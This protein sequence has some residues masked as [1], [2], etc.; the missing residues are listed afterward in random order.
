MKHSLF[1]AILILPFAAVG[2]N[3]YVSTSGTD[4]NEGV[5]PSSPLLTIQKAVDLCAAGDTVFVAEG[6]YRQSVTMRN[7]VSLIGKAGTILDGT[8]LGCRL[9][10]AAGKGKNINFTE[11]TLIENITLQNAR[12]DG[13]GGAAL[14]SGNVTMRYCTVRG[15]SAEQAGGVLIK[16]DLAEASALG[17][18]LEYCLIHNCSATGHNWPDAGGV[19]NFDGIVDHC[20]IV[21][22]YGDRYG[23]IHSESTV[24]NT[25]MW[26]NL[27]EDGF[28][29]PANYVSDES[30]SAYSTNYAN[31]GFEIDFFCEPWLS[32][33]N[34]DKDAPQFL[35]PTNFAGVPLSA[36]ENA[37]MLAA[38]YSLRS[39]SPL[40][41]KAGASGYE[42]RVAK[43]TNI[44]I[45]E[46]TLYIIE[47]GQGS[48]HA[49]VTPYETSDKTIQWSVS[50]DIVSID[51]EGRL[52]AHSVGKTVVTA[53]CGDIRDSA[54]VTVTPKPVVIVHRDV[55]L[56]DSL[57]HIEDYTT[58]SYIPLLIAK[59][60]AR[61][62]SSEH[63]LQA[64]RYAISDLQDNE[65]PYCMV[66]NINGDPATRM[67]FC[68]FTNEGIS[69]GEVQVIRK[70]N[71]TTQ[72]FERGK[73]VSTI[74]AD[75]TTTP[76]L[77]YAI[78][79]S[80]I[81]K[82]AR[83]DKNTSFRYVSHKAVATSLRP[84]SDYS[85]RVGYDGHWSEIMQF[86]TEDRRQKDF[87]FI[88]MTDSH[89][90]NRE[91]VDAA[92]L[93]A[94]AVAANE[95]DAR[96][97]VF[98]GDFV[99]TGTQNNS[100]W[101]WE[102]WFEEALKPVISI[103]PIVP[104]DGNH[105]DSPLLNYT[106]HF[107]TDSSFNTE[108]KVKPQFA[109]ITYSFQYG[110][111]LLMAYSM[112]DFWHGD[113]SYENLTSEYFSRDL[114][115]WFERQV[116]KHPK[117]QYRVALVHKNL[118][119][120]SDH[121]RDK[122]TPLMRQTLLPVFKECEIDL[123]L[124]GHDHTYEVI[125]PV[126]PDTRT[127]ILSAISEQETVPIDSVKN[128]TG[129]RGGTYDVSDGT[130]YFIGATCGAKRY[131]PLTRQEM[132][133]AYNT[134]KLSNY[135]DLFTGMFGQPGAPSYTRITVTKKA[136]LLDSFK[137][138]PDGSTTLFNSMRVVRS[139]KHK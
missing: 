114:A 118:F 76:P 8:G 61:S 78:S 22:N 129:K 29:D 107:N 93:C 12:H 133:D 46:D 112:Q 97:C 105:D 64:L 63:N 102:R 119:S 32:G 54:V 42:P 4:S 135:F 104:T 73:G 113:Y 109:G 75:A 10:T 116:K 56:A 2:A 37:M 108:T 126:D 52:T 11:P 127:P 3:R 59:E 43:C 122:E 50:S 9:I 137:V 33:N 44:D 87:S 111:M 130:M 70:R 79:T 16:G 47:D 103:M 74:H 17:A 7:G 18:K 80:G 72:D 34:R 55:L 139:R 95:R 82:A 94:T 5:K 96:F 91:Y 69:D 90:Q 84:G 99:D 60:T 48:L 35:F 30:L 121:Q 83:L 138:N 19:A 117:A 132:D 15:C 92:K 45:L 125:G 89:L 88:Y 53:T 38:D 134:H 66:A 40:I 71:A 41:N 49:V 21:N 57:Y 31:E 14:L 86:R 26:G 23:G 131:T 106:Y 65:S 100:E 25:V 36:E 98:P 28:V 20:T 62:D 1:I 136:L 58:P 120:G 124:Q 51:S 128:L 85:W 68:W 77:H 24:T 115:E 123:V 39:T 67:A 110:D 81:L 27:S 13:L 101:E 6:T